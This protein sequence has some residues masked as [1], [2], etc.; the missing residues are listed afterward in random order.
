MTRKV[1]QRPHP[2]R[3]LV[4]SG[5]GG[6]ALSPLLFAAGSAQALAGIASN[7]MGPAT[8]FS[9]DTIAKRAE[10]LA[11]RPYEKPHIPSPDL[12]SALTYDEYQR[13]RYRPENSIRLGPDGHYPVQLFH[14]GKFATEPVR[15]HVI[16]AGAAREVI[17]SPELFDIP[18]DSPAR[19]LHAG[20]GFAGF[21]IMADD[22]KT[23]WFAAMGASYFRT[24]GPFN[25][26]G[27]SARGIAIDTAMPRPEEFPRFSQFWLQGAIEPNGPM[28]I[29]A[30]LEGPSITGAYRMGTKRSVNAEGVARI[31]MDIEARLF[32]RQDIDRIGI[33]PFSSMF[34]YSETNRKQGADWRPEIHDSDGLA[35]LTGAGERIW[36][37][38]ANPPRV[39]TSTFVDHDMKG[40]GLLQRDRQ[41][42]HYL[43]DGVF[44]EKRPSTWVEPLE[45][46]GEGAVQLVE[47][48]TDDE[49]SDN[50]V[51]YWKPKDQ[52]RSGQ[53]GT[54][55]Y[56]LSWLDDIA[57]PDYLAHTIGT[58]SGVGGRPGPSH[59]RP[60]GVQK[61]VID[62]KGKPF[63]GLGRNDGV[64]L[65]VDA[66]RGVLSNVYNH[67]VVGQEE[68]WRAFFDIKA[69]GSEPVDL[70]AYLRKGSRALTETWIYQYFPSET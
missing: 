51:A 47:I 25:Q 36:R 42:D 19:K 10:D 40:F 4:L 14:L 27:L 28:T 31:D 35:I 8:P 55:R 48:P 32:A 13:I 62:F 66:S 30:L 1:T 52:F 46:W 34:W 45:P 56:R 49:T 23:D 20:A 29:Y 21:R 9:F 54:W 44:Y 58:W 5:A 17:Y 70:R 67:P 59:D 43:D 6:I 38:L 61:F 65:I 33:A 3:R 41:F 68:R 24:S 18:S 16:E 22:L 60:T 50:I 57:F 11:G 15:I 64:E 63:K 69:T 12:L 39:M 53:K 37:P 26:Y 7:E 2:D